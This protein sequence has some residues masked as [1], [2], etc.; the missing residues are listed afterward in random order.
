MKMAVQ[1]VWIFLFLCSLIPFSN[2]FCMMTMPTM[3]TTECAYRNVT[4]PLGQT[5]TNYDDCLEL[6]CLKD[7]SMSICGI[8]IHAGVFVP[9]NGCA[10]SRGDK[11]AFEFVSARDHTLKCEAEIFG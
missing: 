8:G 9:P 2:S 4:L 3:D 7:G 10:I 6:R 1:I 5:L 11:C